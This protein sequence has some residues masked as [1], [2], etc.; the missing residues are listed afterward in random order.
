VDIEQAPANGR[1]WVDGSGVFFVSHTIGTDRFRVR[2][3]TGESTC[4]ILDVTVEQ[5]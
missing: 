1:A 3:C 2:A 4:S 5:R